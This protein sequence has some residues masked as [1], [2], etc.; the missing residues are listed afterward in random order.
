MGPKK[1][2]KKGKK[3]DKAAN[4]TPIDDIFQKDPE[5]LLQEEFVYYFILDY[6]QKLRDFKN[7]PPTKRLQHSFL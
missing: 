3:G 6:D 5:E 2:G 7:K 4:E 1:K